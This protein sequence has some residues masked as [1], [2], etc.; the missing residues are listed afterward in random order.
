MNLPGSASDSAVPTRR[1]QLPADDGPMAGELVQWWYW[2]G[3]L[4]TVPTLDAPSRRFGFELVFFY[5]TWPRT[6]LRALMGHSAISDIAAGTFTYD[7]HL[8]PLHLMLPNRGH[9]DLSLDKEGPLSRTAEVVARTRARTALPTLP[10]HI[11][12]LLKRLKPEGWRETGLCTVYG[13]DNAMAAR[14]GGGEDHLRAAIDGY[15]LK[16]RC[17]TA[18]APVQYY[19]GWAHPYQAGGY[20]YYYSRPRMQAEGSLRLPD[21]SVHEVKGR[22]WFDRQAGDLD[23]VINAGYQWFALSLDGCDDV[24]LAKLKSDN[25]DPH[26]DNYAAVHSNGKLFTLEPGQFTVTELGSWTS[27]TTGRTY[28]NHWS[29]RVPSHGIDVTVRPTLQEQELVPP[30]WWFAFLE[31]AYW[32][33]A[34]D[35]SGIDGAPLGRAYVE[36]SNW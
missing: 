6:G 32:E 8:K 3:H 13:Q 4:D 27:P 2:T 22:A 5:F 12:Q 24:M 11:E 19:G 31:K 9:F 7:E 21:G 20:T 23:R 14:G 29:L 25:G 16:L 34:C 10:P 15:E 35:V 30:T 17:S 18:E 33:G 1:L 26:P 28:P 36:V